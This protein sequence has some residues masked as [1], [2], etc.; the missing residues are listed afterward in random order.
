MTPIVVDAFQPSPPAARTLEWTQPSWWRPVWELREG[1]HVRVVLRRAH[2]YGSVLLADIEGAPWRCMRQGFFE[3]QMVRADSDQPEMSFRPYGWHGDEDTDRLRLS[4]LRGDGPIECADGRRWFWR[5][6]GLIRD[7]YWEVLDEHDRPIL[8][9]RRRQRPFHI[10][11]TVGV[12]A[13]VPLEDGLRAAVFGWY[14][15]LRETAHRRHA[16]AAGAG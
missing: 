12:G 4:R 6:H 16:A 7:R 3:V 10:D 2:W 14:L 13:E 5:Q 9:L 1:E 11:G 8:T 15:L